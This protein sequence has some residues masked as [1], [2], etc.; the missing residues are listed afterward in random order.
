MKPSVPSG[1]LSRRCPAL[2]AWRCCRSWPDCCAPIPRW[3][4]PM[5]LPS[6]NDGATKASIIDFVARVT[7]QGGPDFVPPDRAHRHLRQRRHAVGRA[8][9]VRPARLRARPRQGAG[10]A[11]PGLE[12]QAAV[13]GGARGR[14]EGAGRV[15]REGPGRADRGDA[16]RHDDGRVRQDRLRLARDRARSAVQAALHRAGLPADAGAA[17]LSARQRLQDLHRLRRRH[18]VHAAVDRARLRHSA[19]AGGRL[20]DQDAGSRC[21]T[22][23]PSCSACR[24]STSSTTRPASRSASTSTSAAARSPRSATPTAI[25]KCCNGRR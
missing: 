21:A 5:P 15:R 14:H 4:K 20:V 19:R 2:D 22:A 18:R 12:D 11:E 16:R 23:G 25:S 6:W 17:R 24:R 7:T 10:A 1:A 3:R 9:D 13:Q 8:A